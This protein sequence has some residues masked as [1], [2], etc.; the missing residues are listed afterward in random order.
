MMLID[1]IHVP[2]T[3]PFYRDGALYL[4]KL[5]HNVRRYSLTPAAGLVLFVPGLEA[6][7]LSDAEV[8][9]CLQS[10]RESAAPEKVLIAGISR[11]SVAQALTQA[12]QAHDAMFDAVM[13]SAPPSWA[14]MQRRSGEA[15]LLNYFRTVADNS[16]LPV[17]LWSQGDAPGFA[18][19]VEAIAALAKHPN[20]LALY[21]ANLDLARLDAIKDATKDVVHE[22]TVT[23]I[24]RPV[25]R[26]ML[27][28]VEVASTS[29]MVSLDA[30]TG[31]AGTSTAVAEMQ[32]PTLKTRTRKLGFNVM[33]CGK[34]SE[35]VPLWER[36]AN[37]AMSMLAA[38]AP[39]AVH[40]SY[41]AFT[42]GDLPLAALKAERLTKA[43][44]ALE[45]VG[46]AAAKY[47]Q[48]V[49]AYF[50][51]LPRLPIAPVNSEEKAVVDDAFRELRN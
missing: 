9:D 41:A 22:A 29:V 32:T 1:G 21:D 20:I 28:P 6:N 45:T 50:G 44:A 15:E 38:P 10:V 11:D 43:D 4:R 46:V 26:R 51:G 27:A 24:F 37:G 17:V 19:S 39:Q 18:L 47:A 25:T 14:Q 42:D 13:L 34:A 3:I 30:L 16:P 40:E 48:D 33:A 7:T 2:L 5:E 12:R 8:L 49:N 36:G 35:M 23:H 31:G